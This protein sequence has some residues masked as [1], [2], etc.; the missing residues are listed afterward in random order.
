MVQSVVVTV[1]TQV[2]MF[3]YK[4]FKSNSILRLQ[5]YHNFIHILFLLQNFRIY[6]HLDFRLISQFISTKTMTPYA[7]KRNIV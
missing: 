5:F 2:L 7:W 3:L 6:Q 1:Q 4:V